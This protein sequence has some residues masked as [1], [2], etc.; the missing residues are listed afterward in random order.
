MTT[1]RTLVLWDI[2][3]TLID[4]SGVTAEIYAAA[5]RGATGQPM[6][7]LA[8]LDGRTERAIITET[9][10][11]HGIEAS[12]ERIKTLG[13]ALASAFTSHRALVERRG[14]ALPGAREALAALAVRDDLVQSVLTGNMAPIAVGKLAA[15]G[16]HGFVDFDVGAYGMDDMERPPLVG[17]ARARAARKYAQAFTSADT[18]VVGDTPK[19]VL[20]GHVG[21]ARVVAVAT[22]ASDAD[23]LRAA[24]AEV[25]LD[26]LTE[27]AAVVRAILSTS[28]R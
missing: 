5:F 28:C 9:L 19:D 12:D 26:D 24:G 27:T 15:F 23:A 2:D 3:R 20:A 21:G 1:E 6:R 4:V 22:G 8:D 13:D 16:L 10:Q 17:V 25:V 11:L 18:V 7:R 14:R